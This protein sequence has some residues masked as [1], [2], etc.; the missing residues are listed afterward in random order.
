MSAGKGEV[1]ERGRV[2]RDKRRERRRNR[3][4]ER[5]RDSRESSRVRSIGR[6]GARGRDQLFCYSTIKCETLGKARRR[7]QRKRKRHVR[8]VHPCAIF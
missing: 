3:S 1:K 5:R 7:L 4:W 8:H 6:E 2:R